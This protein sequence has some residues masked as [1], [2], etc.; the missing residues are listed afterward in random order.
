M[1]KKCI[2]FFCKTV[3]NDKKCKIAS[4]YST[5]TK[6]NDVILR[7]LMNMNGGKKMK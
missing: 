5:W 3:N 2:E 6:E 7:N 1:K 4:T